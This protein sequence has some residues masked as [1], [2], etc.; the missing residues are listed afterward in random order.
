MILGMTLYSLNK[1]ILRISHFFWQG[2]K[3]IQKIV[4]VVIKNHKISNMTAKEKKTI[5]TSKPPNINGRRFDISKYYCFV[6]ANNQRT[7]EQNENSW[8][9]SRLQGGSWSVWP[10]AL[11]IWRVKPSFAIYSFQDPTKDSKD[12]KFQ[13]ISPQRR[14]HS[15][16]KIWSRKMSMATPPPIYNY[17]NFK[18]I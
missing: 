1:P 17:V 11:G 12:R 10:K 4:I 13:I 9:C 5:E 7:L 15:E 8:V 3:S 14:P 18:S 6:L 16:K 2:R